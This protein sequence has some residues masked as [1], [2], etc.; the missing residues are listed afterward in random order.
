L[1]PV[2]YP[3]IIEYIRVELENLT[4]RMFESSVE[5]EDLR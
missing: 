4:S 3:N 1:V 5:M 2:I